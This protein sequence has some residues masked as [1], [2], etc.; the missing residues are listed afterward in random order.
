[1]Y[2]RAGARPRRAQDVARVA[3]VPPMADTVTVLPDDRATPEPTAH[4]DNVPIHPEGDHG[5]AEASCHIRRMRDFGEGPFTPAY[6]IR[7]SM[8]E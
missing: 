3:S 7:G 6:L 8:T 4:F 2:G 5:A 1:M